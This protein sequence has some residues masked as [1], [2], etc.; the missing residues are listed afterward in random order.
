VKTRGPHI[1]RRGNIWYAYLG[2]HRSHSLS[3]S[4]EA[5]ARA[6]FSDLI[7][8][9]VVGAPLP[10]RT[11]AR[12]PREHR[13]V[14]WIYF[15]QSG[16]HGPIKIGWTLDI[17]GRLAKLQAANPEELHLRASARGTQREEFAFHER[18]AVDRIRLE[19][20]RPSFAI[21]SVINELA[22]TTQSTAGAR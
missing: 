20:F 5:E 15:V 7:A 22:A 6:K 2:H 9:R 11:Q 16:T 4:D 8:L 21:L 14:G 17:A 13:G 18:F 10:A 3:T 19:W 12:G 1:Y